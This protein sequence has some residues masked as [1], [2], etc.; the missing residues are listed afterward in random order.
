MRLYVH[1]H[2]FGKVEAKFMK[3]KEGHHLSLVLHDNKKGELDITLYGD[4]GKLSALAFALNSEFAP[5]EQRTDGFTEEERQAISKDF[6][7]YAD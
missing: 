4:E 5:Q 3:Y 1:F 2:D 6:A 7:H